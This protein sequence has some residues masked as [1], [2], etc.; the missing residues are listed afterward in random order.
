MFESFRITLSQVLVL[1]AFISIGYA[2]TKAGILSR[3]FNKGL[4]G[5][6]VNVFVPCLTFNNMMNNFK[7]ET[8]SSKLE[9]MII[10]IVLLVCFLI[11]ALVFSRIFAKEKNTRDVYMYSFTFPNTG[12]FGMPLIL[13][14]Y[15][16]LMLF[17]YILFCIPFLILTYTF[18]IYIL[19]PNRKFDFKSIFNP[20]MVSLVFGMLAGMI[21]LTLPM[22]ATN[23]LETGANCLAPAAMILTGVVFARNDLKKMLSNWK[24]YFACALKMILIPFVAAPII[25]AVNAPQN[26][27][28]IIIVTLTLPTGLNSIILPEAYGG[29]SRTGAQL[30][31]VSTLTT[32]IVLPLILGFYQYLAA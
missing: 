16:E 18:G 30:C 32:L 22:F 27:A 29:D 11:I 23:I 24:V 26:I 12:Y 5:L 19:N 9:I 2:L 13:A 25:S 15:G 31:F 20:M 7:I 10:S 3:D 21:N 14:I 4:A 1:F 8:I 17:D 6:L 28:I